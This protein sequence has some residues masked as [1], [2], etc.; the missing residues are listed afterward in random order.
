MPAARRDVA[1]NAVADNADGTVWNERNR[2]FVDTMFKNDHQAYCAATYS[3]TWEFVQRQNCEAVALLF[4]QGV[5]DPW[6]GSTN[7]EENSVDPDHADYYNG[8]RLT[9]A[10]N[11]NYA[12]NPS[13][14]CLPINYIE[15]DGRPFAGEK[16][17]LLP[18]GVKLAARP[19]NTT[20]ESVEV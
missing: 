9:A 1:L 3:S 10:S 13:N 11:C 8:I 4:Y 12:T 5:R 7:T 14:R 17:A 19:R 2:L 16:I 15:Y 20:G 18:V 6:R